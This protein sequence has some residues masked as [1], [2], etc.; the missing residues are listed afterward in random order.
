MHKLIILVEST[1]TPDFHVFWPRFLHAAEDIPG[2]RREATSRVSQVIYGELACSMIH[3]LYFDSYAALKLGLASES[4]Q[5]AGRL[6]QEM[7]GGTVKLIIADHSEDDLENIRRY[8][9]NG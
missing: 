8:K 6:L 3:E 1:A 7:T 2:L 5:E 4:G 9:T